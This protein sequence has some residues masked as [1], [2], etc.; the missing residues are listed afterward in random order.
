MRKRNRRGAQPRKSFDQRFQRGELLDLRGQ[1]AGADFQQS[2]RKGV[3]N[4]EQRAIYRREEKRAS[5]QERSINREFCA[6]E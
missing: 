5:Q 1:T 6:P 4:R 2:D 3:I